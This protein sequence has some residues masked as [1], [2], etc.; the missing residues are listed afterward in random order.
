MHMTDELL[1][2]AIMADRLRQAQD[3]RLALGFRHRASRRLHR[4]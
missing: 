3:H 1:A 4:G 2:K